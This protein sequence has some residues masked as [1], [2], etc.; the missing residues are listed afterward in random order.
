MNYPYYQRLNFKII[1]G[2]ILSLLVIGLPFFSFFYNFH[3]QQLIDGLKASTTN[4]SKLVVGTLETAML[5]EEPHL[6]NDEIKR[7]SEQSGV[8]QIMI[9]NK[10]GEL[11]I[12]SQPELV[13]KVFKNNADSMCLVCHQYSP[14]TRKNT[15]II[16]DV[17]GKEVFRNMNIIYNQPRCYGCHDVKEKINGILIMDLSMADMREQLTSSNKKIFSMAF[18]MVVITSVVLGLLVNKLILQRIKK[19]TDTT[20]RISEGNLDEVI[21]FRENDEIGN[22][23]DN[24][25]K[26]TANLKDTLN[27][28]KRHKDY[29]EHV[30]NGIEDEIVVVDR[31]YKIVKANEAYLRRR[32]CTKD[33][34]VGKNCSMDLHDPTNSCDK[35]LLSGCPARKTFEK[36]NLQKTLHSF[37]DRNGRE[38]YLEIFCSP[39]RDESG[40]VFQVIELRRDISERKFLEEQLLHTEK[41]TS[42]GRLAA[43]VA[44]E[45]NNPLD[46]I[47]NCLDII[48]KNPGDAARVNTMLE[49]ISEGIE[50]IGLIVRRL[51]IF[52]KHHK[53]KMETIDL[54]KVIEQ[55]LLFIKHKIDNQGIELR[56][57]LNKGFPEVFGDSYNLSQ[58]F[59]NIL[60]NALDALDS[61]SG[62]LIGIE[63]KTITQNSNQFLQVDISDNGCGITEENMERIFS[64]FFTTKDIEKGTGLGLSISQKIVEEHGGKIHI[65]SKWNQGTTVSVLLPLKVI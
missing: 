45:I 62:G 38:K 22:L 14:V 59:I 5:N 11:K 49:L 63:T 54:N 46:G 56:T 25:N 52:S 21:E 27:E 26:M 32:Q 15:T 44:H 60:I 57:S 65:I 35:D 12:S 23:A 24:F 8:E 64:P 16:K 17:T 36:G 48:Q 31:N 39:L 40:E 3:K 34:I 29:L 55:S 51:L 61:K 1:L 37:P 4:L 18:I 30:I 10:Q 7:L 43:S 13:S 41:L 20:L 58:V 2:L 28:V 9:L 33:D 6:L 19:F 53:Q 47:Q 42:I 50:R